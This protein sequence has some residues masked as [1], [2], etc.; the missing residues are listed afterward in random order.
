[1][2]TTETGLVVVYVVAGH[3]LASIDGH[4][5]TVRDAPALKAECDS[6]GVPCIGLTPYTDWYVSKNGRQ[7]TAHKTHA[8]ARAAGG[9][10]RKFSDGR[11]A[12]R[13]IFS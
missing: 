3:I 2:I 4:E 9:R 10:V 1:M 7:V 11:E 8:A 12:A 6:L 13:W 5:I